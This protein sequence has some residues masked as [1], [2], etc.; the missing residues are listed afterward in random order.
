MHSIKGTN[1]QYQRAYDDF[2]TLR[3]QKIQREQGKALDK[4]FD[5]IDLDQAFEIAREAF[6]MNAQDKY[7]NK[8]YSNFFA[9]KDYS[10]YSMEQYENLADAEEKYY[11]IN[12]MFNKTHKMIK[13]TEN[14]TRGWT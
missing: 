12:A 2:M 13:A 6:N 11:C 5:K 9:N 8:F 7:S 1:K 4:G 3:A 14:Q 10:N